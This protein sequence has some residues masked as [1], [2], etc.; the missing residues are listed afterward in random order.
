MVEVDG[1]STVTSKAANVRKNV[2]FYLNVP[3]VLDYLLLICLVTAFLL[4]LRLIL[5]LHELFWNLT[6]LWLIPLVCFPYRVQVWAS[7]CA[8]MNFI[9]IFW[10]CN[11]N[12]TSA[13]LEFGFLLEIKSFAVF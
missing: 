8:R 10:P 4:A 6:E 2:S 1:V 3:L 9:Q 12:S 7:N 5:C 11:C 13:R